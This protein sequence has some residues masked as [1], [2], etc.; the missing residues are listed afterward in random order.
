MSDGMGSKKNRGYLA[1]VFAL[2]LP[3]FVSLFPL[4]AAADTFV[5][6]DIAPYGSPDG[7]LNA[8]DVVVVLRFATGDLIPTAQE[9]LIAD[10]APLGSP[11]GAINIADVVVLQRAIMGIIPPLDPIVIGI[12]EPVLDAAISPTNDNPYLVT[13]SGTAGDTITL[14]VNGTSQA[15]TV[16]NATD[17][18]FSFSA[19]L[20]DGIN[21]IYATAQNGAGDVSPSSN[22]LSVEYVNNISRTQSATTIAAGTN[23]VWT[24]GSVPTAYFINN[25]LTIAEGATLTLRPGVELQFAANVNNKIQANGTLIVNGTADTPVVFTS[26]TLTR[27]AWGGISVNSASADTVIDNARIEWANIGIQAYQATNVTITNSVIM[28]FLDAGIYYYYSVGGKLANN[29]I[30]NI[31]DSGTCIILIASSTVVESNTLLNCYRGMF[32]Q[33][34][35]SPEPQIKSNII[36]SNNTGIFLFNG[37][38]PTITNG[39]IISNNSDYG[40]SLNAPTTAYPQPIVTGNRIFNNGGVGGNY[41][42]NSA[43][44]TSVDITLNASN[45]YWGTTNLAGIALKIWD[46]QDNF[47]Y[48][49]VDFTPFNDANDA[50]VAGDYLDDGELVGNNVLV[51]SKTYDVTGLVTVPVGSTLTIE[52]GATL[53][54]TG[55]QAGLNIEGALSIGDI[56]SG[57]PVTLTSSN[58]NPAPGSWAGIIIG[59]TASV[60]IDNAIIEWATNGIEI[61]GSSPIIQGSTIRNNTTGIAIGIRSNAQIINGNTITDNTTGVSIVGNGVAVDNP[62]PVINGNSIFNNSFLN[63][64]AKNF[65]NAINVELN[66]RN[67]WWGTTLLRIL[68]PSIFSCKDDHVGS[69]VVD[70]YPYWAD[71]NGSLTGQK[72]LS[73]TL[74][75][76]VTIN[77]SDRYAVLDCVTVPAGITVTANAG[78]II[79]LAE[80]SIIYVN[81][82]FVISGNKVNPVLMTEIGTGAGS[83]DRIV[84]N[85]SSLN[86]AI[87]YANV[88]KT[89]ASIEINGANV[90]IS[91]S[92]FY[93]N[94]HHGVHYHSGATGTVSNSVFTAL[95]VGKGP[96]GIRVRTGAAPVIANNHFSNLTYG[97]YM[98]D[99]SPQ[100]SGNLF[101]DNVYGIFVDNGSSPAIDGNRIVANEN[102]VYIRGVSASNGGGSSPVLTGNTIASNTYGIRVAGPSSVAP[103]AT[104]N[105]IY[106]NGTGLDVRNMGTDPATV[107]DFTNNW[108]GSPAPIVGTDIVI[109]ADSHAGVIDYSNPASASFSL[110]VST[111][112]HAPMTIHPLA[113][114]LVTVTFTIDKPANVSLRFYAETDG[115]LVKEI[116]QTYATIGEKTLTWDGKNTLGNYVADEAYYY[117]IQATAGTASYV[118]Q[119]LGSGG[120]GGGQSFD[121]ND[122]SNNIY[123]DPDFSTATNDFFKIPYT[124]AYTGRPSSGNGARVKVVVTPRGGSAVTVINSVPYEIGVHPLMWDGRDPNGNVIV[125]PMSVYAAAPLTL[126]ANVVIV[127]GTRP[128]IIGNGVAP[129]IEVKSNPY[130]IMHSYDQQSQITYQIDM[131]ANVTVKLLPPGINDPAD[132]SAIVLLNN[133]PQSALDT[134]GQPLDHVVSWTGYVAGDTNNILTSEDGPYTFTIEATGTSTGFKTLY[135]GILQLAQ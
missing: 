60:D 27:G 105:D 40:I 129:N 2:V 13:G 20:D 52:P 54:F 130:S 17:G 6:G 59:A 114:E 45:N 96:T 101:E 78:S 55:S 82:D 107:L 22:V 14:Y 98:D 75:A 34:P 41:F 46:N 134:A 109:A 121:P 70:I 126:N 19:V 115:S 84:I 67:N 103:I 125:G 87:N 16:A 81:G 18:T 7:Q 3:L 8:G 124:L 64:S 89:L 71:A 26:T 39:N 90:D 93:G 111:V 104:G 5:A 94:T 50:E 118:Y 91:N 128:T 135:R 12:P 73:G 10:V 113:G 74:T 15:T 11:D 4:N 24:A 56:A 116:N 30:D 85:S 80:N 33:N 62:D 61:N 110:S 95:G 123:I 57:L 86:S 106:G 108:W 28:Q 49:T 63:L 37:S 51:A 21:T 117:E 48:P 102:G 9:L 69:P 131:D 72:A 133:E 1:Q 36:Q 23:V 53:R 112:S 97:I 119:I 32:V 99:A 43:A 122:P 132:P 92:T 38:S 44:V 47:R 31:D 83:W 77:D 100:I 29:I 79:R 25:S 88:D 66:A 120:E 127:K 76:D 58:P 35:V 68:S 42:I 65:G